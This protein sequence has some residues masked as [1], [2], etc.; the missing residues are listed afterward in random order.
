[1]SMS[2][3]EPTRPWLPSYAV[4]GTAGGA[5]VAGGGPGFGGSPAL[6]LAACIEALRRTVVDDGTDQAGWPAWSL[7]EESQERRLAVD[8]VTLYN[9][10]AGVAWALGTLGRALDRPD[11]G[12]VAGRAAD[13]V[14]ANLT[15]LPEGSLLAGRAGAVLAAYATGREVDLPDDPP[16]A[17]D[18]TAGAAGLLLAQVRTGRRPSA[19]LVRA[20]A[21]AAVPGDVGWGWA[22]DDPSAPGDPAVPLCGLAHGASGVA[23]ALAEA[24]VH[25]SRP[26]PALAL[27]RGALEW[28]A[29]WFDP[30]RGWPDLRG[31]QSGY[32]VWWCHGAAGVTA[33]RLR[34][35]DLA[36]RGLD[37]GMPLGSV[38][39]EA[40]AGLQLCAE[41]V[42][43]IVAEAGSGGA[44][45]VPAGLSLCHGL[46]G[47][48]DVLALASEITGDPS[49]REAAAAALCRVASVLGPDPLTWPSGA[50]VPGSCGL[51]LGVAGVAVV[52]ARL[53]WPERGIPSPSL[54]G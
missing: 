3:A 15:L 13:R 9:G 8:D 20:L 5:G 53:A 26:E 42:D 18:L 11:L 14:L 54:L 32:P 1:M 48:L 29:A 44:D 17:S 50:G 33:V 28:E 10:D 47:A 37:L 43:R 4:D 2:L 46:G 45:A 22:D 27:V 30:L 34:L 36:E 38:R 40:H 31:G 12:D 16:G 41:H 24:A 49:H 35:L 21:R 23:L 52:A 6:V 19:E 39:A 51:F 25:L 7:G